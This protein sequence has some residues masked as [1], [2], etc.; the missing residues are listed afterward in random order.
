VEVFLRAALI[1]LVF[2]MSPFLLVSTAV[3]AVLGLA[4]ALIVVNA[5]LEKKRANAMQRAAREMGLT[6][7]P[8]D[9]GATF[10]LL[11]GFHLFS[12]GHSRRITSLMLGEVSDMDVR[13][14]DYSY[15]TGSGTNS[16]TC[17][18]TV[19]SFRSR[20]LALP[21]FSLR[22]ENLFHK[23]G[24]LFG[25][26]DINFDTHPQFSKHYLLRGSDEEAIRNAFN[27]G[28]LE[29]YDQNR[30][31]CTE[32]SGPTLI[33]YRLAQQV[34]PEAIRSFMEV[35]FKVAGLFMK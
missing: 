3:L 32:G 33:F 14:F 10:G 22:P 25:Y 4:V 9:D 34:Q 7:E 30:G 26:Q 20:K 17:R 29:F 5:R 11:S 8:K 6:F 19:I 13:I 18:Q 15:T 2:P 16:H 24:A 35:G 12:Q 21:A 1:A 23:I 27:D 28:V 31:L